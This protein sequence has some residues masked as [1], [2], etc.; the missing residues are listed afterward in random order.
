MAAPP[1][2]VKVVLLGDQSVGKSSLVLR[3][4][5]NDF[6]ANMTSTI[7]ASFMSKMVMVDD[8]PYKFQIWDTAGQEIYHSLAPM[9]YRGA[10]AAL[11]V[12]DITNEQSFKKLKTWVGELE[13]NGP[14]GIA[15]AIAGNKA[16]L[17]ER[18][19]V[20]TAAAAEYAASIGATYLETSAKMDSNVVEIF[21]GLARTL[22]PPQPSENVGLILDPDRGRGDGPCC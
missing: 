13:N 21:S 7:G 4:V 16:D 1:R 9:Y 8:V 22:Q 11:L 17:G 12:Y 18:R 20:D 10:A 3:F 15:L 19:T 6:K 2:E 5:T 14:P